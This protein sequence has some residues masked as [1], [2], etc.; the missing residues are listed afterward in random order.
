MN[1]G[2]LIAMLSDLDPSIRLREGF[3]YPDSYRGNYCDVAF[4]PAENVTIGEMLEHAKSAVG[5]TFQGYKGGD[6]VMD[7]DSVCHIAEYGRCSL[8]GEDDVLTT[9]RLKYMLSTEI[10]E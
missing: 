4:E 1:L 3:T 6:Y 2:E 8:D 9:W 10:K 7:V 5:K